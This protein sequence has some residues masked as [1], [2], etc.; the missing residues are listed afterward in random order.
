M[1]AIRF[2]LLSIL[3]T[4][5]Q[6]IQ[7]KVLCMQPFRRKNNRRCITGFTR[8]LIA[9]WVVFF[10]ITGLVYSPLSNLSNI[11]QAHAGITI[12]SGVIIAWPSTAASIPSGWSRV[13]ALDT[14]Y[15][16]GV[17]NTATDPG[18]TGGAT[19]HTHTTSAHD[20]T[21]SHTHA[22]ATSGNATGSVTAGTASNTDLQSTTHTHTTGT[23]AAT[24][25][26]S[27]TAAPSSSATSNDPAYLK[28]IWIQSDGS[29]TGIPNGALAM[30]NSA[31]LPASW[32]IYTNSQDKF[33]KGADASGDGGA[34]GGAATHNHTGEGSHTHISDHVHPNGTT[35]ASAGTNN[36][37]AAGST[38]AG[39]VHTHTYTVS[40]SNFGTSNAATLNTSTDNHEP[41]WQKLAVIENQ[42]GG[43]D[44]PIGTIAIWRGTLASIP[45]GWVVADGNNGTP[46]LLGDFVKGVANTGEIGNTGGSTSH[47]HTGSNH[48]HTWASTAHTHTV[49][50]TGA[51]SVLRGTAGSTATWANPT[52]THT[53]TSGAASAITPGNAAPNLDSAT[54]LP[55]YEEV[56]YIMLKSTTLTT[57]TNPG[58]STIAPGASA[59]QVN[60]FILTTDTGTDAITAITVSLP[61]TTGIGTIAIHSNSSCTASLG[62]VGGGTGSGI[63]SSTNVSI[64]STN[65]ITSGTT[66]YVCDTPLSHANMPVPDGGAYGITGNATDWTGSNGQGGKTAD[67]SS[68]ITID[69]DSPAATTGASATPG[70]TTVDVGWT[71]PGDGDFQQVY[72]YCKTSSMISGEAPAEGTD[73]PVDGAAW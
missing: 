44:A 68:T 56:A 36:S 39:D 28:V 30:F 13:T 61:V 14:I 46:N 26:N 70:D 67:T 52:H 4:R 2:C 11:P 23:V 8:S 65:A 25:D 21:I 40:S 31:S 59:T 24:T 5:Q 49:N 12:P 29:P 33:L 37:Y 35:A 69:N 17:P 6:F 64:S 63:T 71:A 51:P 48:T 15:V 19:T 18:T 53:A 60:S 10:V 55:A 9:F 62:S 66:F 45:A 41:P 7:N 32:A 38:A 43:V 58:N 20:H 57:G 73:P 22:T 1:V 27:G 34:T 3:L 72:I 50:I 42:T 47:T 54:H 16:R